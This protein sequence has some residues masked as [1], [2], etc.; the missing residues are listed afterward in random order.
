MIVSSGI[1]I[2]SIPYSMRKPSVNLEVEALAPQNYRVRLSTG[3]TPIKSSLP[4]IY[5]RIITQ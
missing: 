3:Y 5:D 2:E 4:K 1:A